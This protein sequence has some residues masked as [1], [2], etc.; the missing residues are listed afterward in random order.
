[1]P[2]DLEHIHSIWDGYVNL[3][4]RLALAN[5]FPDDTAAE[6]YLRR[7]HAGAAIKHG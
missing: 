6:Y 3:G 2:L 7:V 1:V 5:G 4:H